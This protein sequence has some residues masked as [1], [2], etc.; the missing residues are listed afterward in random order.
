ML[1]LKESN[2][3][4]KNIVNSI[5]TI[6][7]YPGNKSQENKSPNSK[8]N[9]FLL[10]FLRA[11]NHDVNYAGNILINY[12][13]Q[14]NTNPKYSKNSTNMEVIRRVY[15][16]QIGALLPHRDQYGRRVYFYRPGKWNPDI[17]SLEDVFCAGYMLCEVAAR[18]PMSQICGVTVICDASD[19]GFKQLRQF[20][21][22]DIKAFSSFMQ[23]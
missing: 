6:C 8:Y 5:P 13:K 18:E 10:K 2:K 14:A 1:Q 22:E 19:F 21:I 17:V 9:E 4:G 16:D 12:I 7:L 11:G 15:E 23:V 20:G 3:A